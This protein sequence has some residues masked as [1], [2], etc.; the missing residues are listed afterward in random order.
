MTDVRNMQASTFLE[1]DVN[2][3]LHRVKP[4]KKTTTNKKAIIGIVIA[5]LAIGYFVS[6][7]TPKASHNAHNGFFG[8]L[9]AKFTGIWQSKNPM[10]GVTVYATMQCNGDSLKETRLTCSK[11][12]RL[13]D[14]N[15]DRGDLIKVNEEVQAFP[16]HKNS[17]SFDLDKENN[18]GDKV[19][20]N[21]CWMDDDAKAKDVDNASQD[22][23]NCQKVTFEK[24]DLNRNFIAGSDKHWKAY[25]ILKEDGTF[26]SFI[27]EAQYDKRDLSSEP[28]G[29][30][31]VEAAAATSSSTAA[32][33]SSAAPAPTSSSTAEAA[34]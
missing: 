34:Q 29:K 27:S 23:K 7:S 14:Y 21:L 17:L 15:I 25:L 11:K 13:R 30:K 8:D 24:A 28:W 33:T 5:L 1:V 18:L 6:S 10:V 31:E 16:I 32:A 9:W 3:T 12:T 19:E 4:T 20:V 2:P 22:F 26:D